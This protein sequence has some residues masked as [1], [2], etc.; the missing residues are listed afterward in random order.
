MARPTLTPRVA[1][2]LAAAQA[3]SGDVIDPA[4]IDVILS[5]PMAAALFAADVLRVSWPDAEPVIMRDLSAVLTYA[6]GVRGRW[7]E[8]ESLILSDIH[9]TI[10]Y[11]ENVKGPWLEAE[12]L[13]SR[14]PWA[15][16]RY[17]EVIRTRFLNG[18]AAIMTDP[19]LSYLYALRVIG[20]PWP[21]AEPTIAGDRVHSKLYVKDVLKT[22]GD[23]ARF[24]GLRQWSAHS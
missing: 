9:A 2:N 4:L 16:F 13:L 6:Q 10:A 7:S 3:R 1:F 19:R 14:I 17:A 11:I 21:E 22:V 15:A 24:A 20:G 12:L 23:R 8:A 5:D 18:E